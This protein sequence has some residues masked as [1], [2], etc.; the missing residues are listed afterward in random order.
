MKPVSVIALGALLSTVVWGGVRLVNNIQYEQ[1]VGGF[2]KQAADA[3]TAALAEEK[4]SRAIRGMDELDLC[5]SESAESP[6]VFSDDCY[7][8]VFWRTPDE[9]IGFWRTN[10]QAT[11]DDLHTMTPEERADNLTESNQLMKVRETLVDHKQSG[12]SVT[13]PEGIS[14]YPYNGLLFWWGLVSVVVCVGAGLT[15]L[16]TLERGY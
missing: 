4:L 3:N 10:V 14:V 1:Q 5:S 6:P 15:R 2:L 12:V 7:T 8:S 13:D 11:Y 16:F 9:D